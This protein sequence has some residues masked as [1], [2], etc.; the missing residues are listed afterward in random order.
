MEP[1]HLSG[2]GSLTQESDRT[3]GEKLRQAFEVARI[4]VAK[5]RIWGGCSLPFRK[6]LRDEGGATMQ[7]TQLKL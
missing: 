6:K 2:D 4:A 7:K 5:N 1:Q 3:V